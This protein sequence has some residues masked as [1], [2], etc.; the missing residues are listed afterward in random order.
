MAQPAP[1][2]SEGRVLFILAADHGNSLERDLYE[3]T[4]SHAGEARHR[5]TA[6]HLDYAGNYL[7]ARNGTPASPAHAEFW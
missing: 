7:A 1:A 4:G 2:R 5:V 6:A 3:V